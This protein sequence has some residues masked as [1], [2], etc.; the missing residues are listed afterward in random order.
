MAVDVPSASGAGSEDC[1]DQGRAGGSPARHALRAVQRLWQTAVSLQGPAP[2]Q[3][4]AVLSGELH[5]AGQEPESVRATRRCADRAPAVTHLSTAADAHRP[6]DQPGTGSVAPPAR[7]GPGDPSQNTRWV[8]QFARQQ[9]LT[10]EMSRVVIAR[11]PLFGRLLVNLDIAGWV[12]VIL[13][14]GLMTWELTTR[15]GRKSGGER[16]PFGRPD[17]PS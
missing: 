1:D 14:V 2:A 6:V 16:G 8:S 17:E 9:G 5:V 12:L 4:R 13:T 10:G 3:T 11:E 7:P 15:K